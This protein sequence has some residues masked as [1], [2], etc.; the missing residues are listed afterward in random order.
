[1]KHKKKGEGI[2][3]RQKRQERREEGAEGKESKTFQISNIKMQ[4]SKLKRGEGSIDALGCEPS[5][6]EIQKIDSPRRH[7]EHRV[8]IFFLWREI[9]PKENPPPL[10]GHNFCSSP[11]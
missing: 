4:I 6:L 8:N 3:R 9:P 1:M 5:A 11:I 7:R 2:K 10:R